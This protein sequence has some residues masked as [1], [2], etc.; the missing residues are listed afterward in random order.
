M[1]PPAKKGNSSSEP[2][3]GKTPETKEEKAARLKRQ[4]NLLE[5]SGMVSQFSIFLGYIVAR[6]ERFLGFSSYG[7]SLKVVRHLI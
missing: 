5:D 4:Q 3:K 2:S 7:N 6:V 1:S